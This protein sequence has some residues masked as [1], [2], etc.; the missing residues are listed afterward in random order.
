MF[1]TCLFTVLDPVSGRLRLAN[2]GHD[3]PFHRTSNGL[4]DLHARGM[5][6]G[7]FPGSSYEEIETS[8]SVG[9]GLLMCSDGLVEAHNPQGEM[10][11]IHRLSDLLANRPF[12]AGVIDFLMEQLA[13]FTGPGWEQEDDVTLV[14][15]KR[16]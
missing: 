16:L 15:L 8:L 11:D 5:P 3:M 14:T 7:I 9:D 1:V 12:D 4:L 6:L 10:F 2:A 13:D